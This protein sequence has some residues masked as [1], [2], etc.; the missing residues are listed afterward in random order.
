M[1]FCTQS[2]ISFVEQNDPQYEWRNQTL[3]QKVNPEWRGRGGWTL[4]IFVRVYSPVLS[5][6]FLILCRKLFAWNWE[7]S[8]WLSV[9]EESLCTRWLQRALRNFVGF[10]FCEAAKVPFIVL[11]PCGPSWPTVQVVLLGLHVFRN[12][13]GICP[14]VVSFNSLREPVIILAFL[15]CSFL[16]W[17]ARSTDPILLCFIVVFS[18]PDAFYNPPWLPRRR[19]GVFRLTVPKCTA[20]SWFSK[21]SRKRLT[22]AF[23]RS[24]CTMGSNVLGPCPRYG[25]SCSCFSQTGFLCRQSGTTGFR[26]GVVKAL[27]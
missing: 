23:P 19:F 18:L 22:H 20:F 4:R 13:S 6:E 21:I 1:S 12:V 16:V 14:T 17:M 7:Q 11:F 26:S 9:Y 27:Y 5:R 24:L 8:A 25:P 3:L 10:V 2:A 15:C